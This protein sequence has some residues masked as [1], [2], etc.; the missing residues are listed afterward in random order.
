MPKEKTN[1]YNTLNI[2][3]LPPPIEEGKDSQATV[4]PMTGNPAQP[5]EKLSSFAI[6]LIRRLLTIVDAID[7]RDR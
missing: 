4:L 6:R 7:H 3:V 2:N 1:K 5:A